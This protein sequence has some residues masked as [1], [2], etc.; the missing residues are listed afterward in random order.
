MLFRG[1]RLIRRH[2]LLPQLLQFLFGGGRVDLIGRPG[3]VR[4]NGDHAPL[5]LYEAPVHKIPLRPG[6][7][8]KHQF[9]RPQPTDRRRATGKDAHLSV[10]QGPAGMPSSWR[11][12][13]AFLPTGTIWP[14]YN[15]NT[16]ERTGSSSSVVSGVTSTSWN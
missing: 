15:G 13:D 2:D 5:D 11:M 10:V 1:V 14:S 4:Q 16:T 3:G 9:T 7:T 12:S 6:M 8:L